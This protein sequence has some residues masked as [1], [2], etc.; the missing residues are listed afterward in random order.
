MQW[1]FGITASN[2]ELIH[3]GVSFLQLKLVLD[4]GVDHEVVNMGIFFIFFPYFILFILINFVFC[5][6]FFVLF[7]ELTLP[8]FYE[9]LQE[10]EKAKQALTSYSR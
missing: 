6:L 10:L 3:S 9:L 8:Q 4:K 7:L 2:S 5:F 1:R